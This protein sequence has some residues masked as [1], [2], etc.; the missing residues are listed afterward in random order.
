MNKF[1]LFLTLTGSV[2][3]AQA[4]KP[5]STSN[6]STV[7][8]I[9]GEYGTNAVAVAYNPATLTY[10]TVFA[11]NASYPLETHNSVG[12]STSTQETGYD[13][14]GMWYNPSKKC[15]EGIAYDN[16]GGFEVKLN[17]DGSIAGTTA[18]SFSYGM[19][20]QSVATYAEKK[21]SIMFVEGSTVYFFKPGKLKTKKV[22]LLPGTDVDLNTFGPIYTGVKNYEIGLLD[23]KTM[24]VVLFSES[25][26]QE[27]GR[28]KLN[29]DN[30]NGNALSDYPSIFR[31][32]YCNG[33]VFVFDTESRTWT[34][35][36]LF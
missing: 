25:T 34:G 8:T 31:V 36:K 22:I 17:P 27:T 30:C 35:Y 2:V 23:A 26:G 13:V 28:V 14:R 3:T 10:Y 7:L 29:V 5:L 24:T 33:R 19:D 6:C 12:T 1:L 11:G 16:Q 9:Q 32:S 20:A 21:K 4:Q 15:L 18:T